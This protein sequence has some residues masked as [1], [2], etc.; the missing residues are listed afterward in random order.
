[1][2]GHF[3]SNHPM[4]VNINPPQYQNF[5]KLG[6]YAIIVHKKGNPGPNIAGKW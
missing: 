4:K 5:F 1:M 2:M 6:I 3:M